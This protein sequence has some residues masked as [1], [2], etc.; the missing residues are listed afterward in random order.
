MM[1]SKP[2]VNVARVIYIILCLLAGFAVVLGAPE[3]PLWVGLFGGLM[4]AIIFILIESSMRSFTLRGFSTAT[5]GIGVGL[6]CAFLLNRA[7]IPQLIE[8]AASGIEIEG[9]AEALALAFTVA[10]YASFAFLGAVLA[11]RS[12]QE[13]FSFIIPY[14]RFRQDAASGQLLILDAEVIMDGRLPSLMVA[15]FLTGRVLVPQFVLD[16]LQ[17]MANS[18]AAAKRQRGQRG[19]E[20]LSELQK[21]PAVPISIQDSRGMAEDESF[22]GRLV[23]TAKLLSARLVTT[24]ENLTKVAHLQG[25]DIIN[26]NDL[27]DALKPSVV[28]GESVRLALVRAGK[29]D[30]QAVGY[31]P[32]GT[33][34]VVNH[35][36]NKIGTSQD[37]TVISTL[38]TSAGQMVFAELNSK[39]NS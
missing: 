17:V 23:Q 1:P 31:M 16:E 4:V 14:V 19:L 8:I 29:D 2:S 35:A 18:P 39:E 20:I 32:D 13:E 5:F 22:Q 27:S 12:D 37:V 10:S 33:M 34:I 7:Q 11:L 6:L 24:D 30:H 21:N 26:L 15:G 28:V 25:A 9:V 38:Q 3:V 36:I